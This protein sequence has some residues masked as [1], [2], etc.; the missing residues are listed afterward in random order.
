[1]NTRNIVQSLKQA[2]QDFEWYPTTDSQIKIVI[3]DIMKIKESFEFTS[4]YSDSVKLLDIGA[5]D[6]RVLQALKA[7]FDEN[8]DSIDLFAIE[9]ASI[10][11][12]S[13]AKKGI[14]LLGT[15]FNETNFI[16]KK[17]HICFVNPPYSSFSLWLQTIIEQLHF[18]VL[19]SVIPDRWVNDPA[20]K[21]AMQVRGLKF[22]E[23]LAESDFLDADRA[24]RA[25]VNIVRFSF[26]DFN[27]IDLKRSSRGYK[28]T[29]G[30]KAS[31]P[32]QNFIEKEL[33]IVKTYSDTTNKFHEYAE[34]ERVRKEMETQG[35]PSFELVASKGVLWAMLDNYE[36]DLQKNVRAIQ[37][38][39][40]T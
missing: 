16:S 11:T 6:G 27:D 1:M 13:Y 37:K 19:Y 38:D 18:G 33:G 3:D 28:A 10:H 17:C 30:F 24:A 34:K 29:V 39:K 5:G 26:E 14:T 36:R 2:C 25:K 7:A 35:T 12:A 31:D 32:F 40:R 4:S 20:I 15:E 23:V 9:K 22:F 8:K 21:S